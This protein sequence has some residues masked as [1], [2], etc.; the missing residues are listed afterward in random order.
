MDDKTLVHS[1]S[2]DPTETLQEALNIEL[3]GTVK[4]KMIINESKC[5]AFTINISKKKFRPTKSK[6]KQ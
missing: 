6:T 3:E 4:D 1:Y 2:G 5:H